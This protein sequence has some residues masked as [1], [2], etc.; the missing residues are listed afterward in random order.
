M[1]TAG[2]VR[3]NRYDVV[4]E[5]VGGVGS[6]PILIAVTAV[7][8]LGQVVAIGVYRPQATA[9]LPVRRLLEK[10]S[11]LR[12]SKAYR[13]NAQRDDFARALELLATQ[14]RDFAS[15]IT[16]TPAWTPG[17]PRPPALESRQPLKT[18]FVIAPR[19]IDGT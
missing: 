2:D 1:V 14:T 15:I 13:V 18:V 17:D 19:S 4:L 6:E 16:A 8:P 9:D 3:A 7:A 5:S 11:T 12:G 10:E